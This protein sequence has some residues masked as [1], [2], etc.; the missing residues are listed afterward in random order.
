MILLT[1]WLFLSDYPGDP[2]ANAAAAGYVY[3]EYTGW[4]TKFKKRK[5]TVVDSTRFLPKPKPVQVDERGFF[6]NK[7]LTKVHQ[8]LN[9]NLRRATCQ[10]KRHVDSA[11]AWQDYSTCYLTAQSHVCKKCQY[12]VNMMEAF[13]NL[14]SIVMCRRRSWALSKRKRV[15]SASLLNGNWSWIKTMQVL[16]LVIF[17]APFLWGTSNRVA[18]IARLASLD[19]WSS[20]CIRDPRLEEMLKDPVFCPSGHSNLPMIWLFIAADGTI[21]MYMHWNSSSECNEWNLVNDDR[22]SLVFSASRTF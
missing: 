22:K 16:H 4:G 15:C 10:E 11:M 21:I 2:W 20:E 9:Q 13:F 6:E 1:A 5:A 8:R 3:P 12:H 18:A 19:R 14:M 17:Q 7:E